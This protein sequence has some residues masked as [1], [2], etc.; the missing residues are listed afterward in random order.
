MKK[1]KLQIL[2]IA[3]MVLF[4]GGYKY[5]SAEISILPDMMVGQ[6][7]VTDT[8]QKT[9]Y[10]GMTGNYAILNGDPQSDYGFNLSKLQITG[11]VNTC[12]QSTSSPLCFYLGIGAD[13]S[14]SAGVNKLMVSRT[15]IDTGSGD[16]FIYALPALYGG[17]T[18]VYG[19]T[20]GAK[21]DYSNFVYWGRALAQAKDGAVSGNQGEMWGTSNYNIDPKSYACW[22][23]D[24]GDD[25]ATVAKINVL[26]GEGKRINTGTM[27]VAA[28]M[29]NRSSLSSVNQSE[30]ALYPEGGIW[31][32]G[33]SGSGDLAINDDVKYKG[34][35]TIIVTGNLNIKAGVKIEAYDRKIDS[36]GFVVFGNVTVN[37][38]SVVEAPIMAIKSSP[39]EG[40]IEIKNNAK[41]LG[42]YVANTFTSFNS[43]SNILIKYDAKLDSL[44]PP[45]FRSIS[46]I[47]ASETGNR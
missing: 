26:K 13:G 44:Q 46:G 40:N 24:N 39:G 32:Y 5:C 43:K 31:S 19:D 8:N 41:L 38:G 10:G 33:T 18:N 17:F 3:F 29:L 28:W 4:L 12:L 22:D 36:L 21:A 45:G 2:L 14:G 34:V 27:P 1:N 37:S 11:A 7:S 42:Y 25:N 16:E 15:M 9:S 23:G 20:Y 47:K 35:G 6:A 30:E